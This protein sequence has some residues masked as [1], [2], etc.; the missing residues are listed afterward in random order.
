[1]NKNFQ[2]WEL[3]DQILSIKVDKIIEDQ[4]KLDKRVSKL[5]KIAEESLNINKQILSMLQENR[6]LYTNMM[7]QTLNKEEKTI[8][9]LNDNRGVYTGMMQE[10]IEVK[11]GR[12][13]AINA[14]NNDKT[15][16]R[17]D[18]ALWRTYTHGKDPYKDPTF[19]VFIKNVL[20][21]TPTSLR[22]KNL[23]KK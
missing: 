19:G 22:K 10:A 17:L 4:S 14:L 21:G 18:N 13:E 3:M 2:D 15:N 6:D 5:E 12:E 1:M 23:Q 16:I 11:N 7:Q 20:F 8:A 9:M